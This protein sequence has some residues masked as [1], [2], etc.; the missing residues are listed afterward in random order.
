MRAGDRD[1]WLVTLWAPA[2]ARAG[3][4][5][6]WALDLA[7]V[8]IVETTTEPRLGEIRLAWWREALQRLDTA[9]PPPEPVL[10]ALAT[11]V[12]PRVTGA[13]LAGLE[14]GALAWLGGDP[15]EA[16]RLRGQALFAAAALLLGGGDPGGAGASW[17]AGDLARRGTELPRCN[18]PARLPRRLRPLLAL[19]RLAARATDEP[20]GSLARQW[21]I[22][23]AMLLG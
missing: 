6:L 3:L 23:R 17:A 22:A 20:S 7:L 11:A 15:G 12:L 2:A 5:A 13:A 16:A 8:R 9:P 10:N 21:T 18:P 19:A 4:F 14:D 1:R